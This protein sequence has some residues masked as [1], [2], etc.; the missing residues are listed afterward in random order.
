[1]RHVIYVIAELL[2]SPQRFCSHMVLRGLSAMAGSS[3]YTRAIANEVGEIERRL[4]VLEKSLEK[5][6]ARTAWK[7]RKATDGLGDTIASAL[8]NWSGRF[9]QSAGLFGQ[10]TSFGKDAARLGS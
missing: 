7:S 9:R 1:M 3:R 4:R 5:I 10:S 2:F 8:S 6:S